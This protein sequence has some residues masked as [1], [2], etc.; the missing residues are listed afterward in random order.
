[1]K[2]TLVILMA[3]ALSVGV[4]SADY[5]VLIDKDLDAAGEFNDDGTTLTT[6]NA[7][8]MSLD[9][10]LTANSIW[11]NDGTQITGG[12]EWSDDGSTLTTL[13]A[14]RA[15]QIDDD[16]TVDGTTFVVVDALN[17]VGIGT[18]TPSQKL[19]VQGTFNASGA[20]TLGSTAQITGAVTALSTV[21]IT[22]TTNMSS[23]LTVAQ[24]ICAADNDSPYAND[25]YDTYIQDDLHVEDNAY[26][27][28]DLTILGCLTVDDAIFVLD[29]T[30]ASGG[31]ISPDQYFYL[32]DSSPSADITENFVYFPD[33]FTV[34]D[35][36]VTRNTT[37]SGDLSANFYVGSFGIGAFTSDS[38]IEQVTFTDS[39]FK[40]EDNG[41][42][43]NAAIAAG[44]YVVVNTGDD[45]TTSV[46]WLLK[47]YYD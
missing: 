41:T 19:D 11:L 23:A 46:E 27:D 16:F 32:A 17:N 2:K 22:G 42:I 4:A 44:K 6:K 36:Y 21:A 45:C 25:A 33:A 28:G 1:M 3:L 8:D 18:D 9:G 12:G 15:V 26:I 5:E 31:K 39:D 37:Q 20:T 29:A 43:D 35:V 7:R 14:N 47:G 13:N 38:T 24:I 34:T 10:D 30:G 40:V